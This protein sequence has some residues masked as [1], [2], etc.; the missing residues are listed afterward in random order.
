MARESIRQR[1]INLMYLVFIAMLALNVSRE[2]LFGFWQM[3]S[4]MIDSNEELTYGNQEISN[5]IAIIAD[6]RGGRWIDVLDDA[7]TADSLTSNFVQYL[8]E[9]KYQSTTK[10]RK[11]DPTLID[12]NQMDSSESLDR[13]FF[14]SGGTTA[15][16]K[17]FINRIEDF[18]NQIKLV[19]SP[20]NED[21]NAAVDER[22]Y[23]GDQNNH[24]V[25]ASGQTVEWL[26]YHYEGFPLIASIAKISMLQ[27]DV[28]QT[29]NDIFNILV[30]GEY[31]GDAEVNEENYFSMLNSEKAVYYQG[32]TFDSEVVL[33]RR[34]RTQNPNEVELFLDNRPLTPSQ[35]SL[36]PGGVQLNIDNLGV[37]DY[38][39]T[40]RLIFLN[41]GVQ[42]IIPIQKTISVMSRP[43]TAVVSADKMNVVYRG[44][45]NPMTIS[46]P[47]IPNNKVSASALGLQ[48]LGNNK[49]NMR[50]STGRQVDINVTGQLSDGQVVNSSSRFRIKEIPKPTGYFRGYSGNFTLPRSSF[51]KG[52]VEARL[53]DFDFDLTLR[54]VSFRFRVPGQPS[55]QI[56]GNRLDSRS[57]NAMRNVRSGQVV[58]IS[59]IEVQ[60]TSN[61]T[62]RMRE[63]SPISITVN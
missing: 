1:L 21:F 43:N 23:T 26:Q 32:D 27:N 54:V 46:I 42:S 36:V 56:S 14:Q 47:G 63:T 62:Y 37:G 34:G 25:N 60:V 15:R 28:L 17:E 49:Y 48:S 58:I 44:I 30:S 10:R 59:D 33:A 52:I 5:R 50:P 8:E 31:R 39:L 35:Y 45:D 18:R 12:F 9:I 24:V 40:G 53:E 11:K 16:G 3:N 51:E 22:F 55:F 29:G 4:K 13:I 20:T 38:N 57:I 2:V 41:E 7:K 61:T 6:E 19:I